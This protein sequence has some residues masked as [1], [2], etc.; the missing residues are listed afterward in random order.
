[1]SR[2]GLRRD[3]LRLHDGTEQEH[4]VV[5]IAEAVVVV[6]VLA[7]GRTVASS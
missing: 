4:H 5:E 1:V 7:D 2:V 3:V 6:P